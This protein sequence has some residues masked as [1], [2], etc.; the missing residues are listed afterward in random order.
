MEK[1]KHLKIE[2][3]TDIFS[4]FTRMQGTCLTHVCIPFFACIDVGW[5]AH[6]TACLSQRA[7]LN[8][9]AGVVDLGFL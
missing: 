5:V 3:N 9:V 4:K 2:T 1:I 6:P 7:E 8:Q